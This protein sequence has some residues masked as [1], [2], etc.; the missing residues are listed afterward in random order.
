VS[1]VEVWSCHLLQCRR[2]FLRVEMRTPPRAGIRRR[3]EE[4]LG[5]QLLTDIS[6]VTGAQCYIFDNPNDLPIIPQHI[7]VEPRNQYWYVLAYS[8][9]NLRIGKWRKIN[10]KLTLLPKTL[11]HL[12]V[13]AKAGYYGWLR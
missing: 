3:R 10:V 11:P 9:S 7:G 8:P 1:S 12:L 13:H 5:P 2:T 4:T 6:G